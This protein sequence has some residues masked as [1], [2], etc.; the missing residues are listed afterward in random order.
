MKYLFLCMLFICLF[1]ATGCKKENP[2]SPIV[3]PDATYIMPWHPN[4]P[5]NAVN[6]PASSVTLTWNNPTAF[7]DSAFYIV[8][9]G[10]TDPPRQ[11]VMIPMGWCRAVGMGTL[12]NSTTYFW[13]VYAESNRGIMVTGPI[14]KFTTAP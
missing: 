4:P 12:W 5:N 3:I 9:F 1:V 13:Y 7:G 11:H 2:I 10:R 8:W 6:V 14:W